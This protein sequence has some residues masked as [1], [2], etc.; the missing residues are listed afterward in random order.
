MSHCKIQVSDP[1]KFTNASFFPEWGGGGGGGSL[2]TLMLTYLL[3]S[4]K[5]LSILSQ[6]KGALFKVFWVSVD[7]GGLRYISA[8]LF[9]LPLNMDLD[10]KRNL[11]LAKPP[12]ISL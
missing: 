4:E 3:P 9:I 6:I 5:A 8:P 10:H 1:D 2:S 12:V 11:C 7:M